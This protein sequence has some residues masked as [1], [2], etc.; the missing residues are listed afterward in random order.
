MS[1]PWSR[2][3]TVFYDY[4]GSEDTE[5][6][7]VPSWSPVVRTETLGLPDPE[8]YPTLYS[9]AQLLYLRNETSSSASGGYFYLTRVRRSHN[10][11]GVCAVAVNVDGEWQ[12]CP[13]RPGATVC[14]GQC[15]DTRTNALNCGECGHACGDAEICAGGACVC[16]PRLA[17]LDL[18]TC[19][20]DACPEGW[21]GAGCRNVCAGVLEG[22][23]TAVQRRPFDSGLAPHSR[24]PELRVPCDDG[25][26]VR[27]QRRSARGAGLVSGAARARLGARVALRCDLMRERDGW[28]LKGVRR[29]AGRPP[30]APVSVQRRHVRLPRERDQRRAHCGHRPRARGAG[31]E[32]QPGG[33]QLER[34]GHRVPHS[35]DV[36]AHGAALEFGA[37]DV[38]DV[39]ADRQRNRRVAPHLGHHSWPATPRDAPGVP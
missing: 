17:R 38:L 35:V 7:L 34:N 11:T 36:G 28:R 12:T 13:E 15:I 1:Q 18:P 3:V 21:Y 10:P 19:A 14:D 6:E 20:W 39:C 33:R 16:D 31:G 37:P 24:T 5:L 8:G 4:Y 23:G 22:D 32:R 25:S 27:G 30:H 9:F 26:K 29:R 2:A